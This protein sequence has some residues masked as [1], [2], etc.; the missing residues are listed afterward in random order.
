MKQIKISYLPEFVCQGKSTCNLGK[1][2]RQVYRQVYQV[3]RCCW[4]QQTTCRERV[5]PFYE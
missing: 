4:W 3:K 1:I 2:T 5:F